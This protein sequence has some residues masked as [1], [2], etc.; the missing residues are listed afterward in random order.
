MSERFKLGA[1]GL[2]CLIGIQAVA[3]F[4][5]FFLHWRGFG[6]AAFSDFMQCALLMFATLA[7]LLNVQKTSQRARLFWSLM[8]LGLASWLIYRMLWTYIEVVQGHEV[9]DPF[10]ADAILFLHFVPM[11]AALVLQPDIR[12]DDTELRLGTL[13]FALLFLWW[14]YLYLYAVIPWQFVQLNESA[15]DHNWDTAYVAEKAAFLLGLALVWWRSSGRWRTTYAH[16][17][18]ASLLYSLSSYVANWAL[19]RNQYYSGSLYDLPLMASMA[20]MTMAGLLALRIP[21]EQVGPA[22]S[23]ARG[24]WTSRIGMVAVF[25]LPIFAYVS[26]FDSSIPERVRIFRLVLTLGAVL[27]MGCLV[28]LKQHFLDIE[29]IRLLRSSRKSF[30]DLQLLQAQLVQSE[31]LASLGQLVGG[32][33]HELN[34]PLT[35]ML[36]YSEL[37]GNTELSPDQRS[38]SEKIA[39]Q[40]KRV[41]TLVASLLSFAK[42]V[43]SAKTPQDLNVIAQTALKLCQPQLHAACVQTATE[44]AQTPPLARGDANQLLQV[45]THIIQNAANAM[46]DRGGGVLTVATQIGG[47][48]V[49]IQFSDTG[50]GMTEPDRVF[51]PFYTTRPVGQGTGLGLSMCYGVVQEH[52][53]KIS[54]R[55]RDAGGAIFLIE[56]PAAIVA[57][58]TTPDAK[59]DEP[60]AQAHVAGPSH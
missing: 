25:S 45:F 59:A 4:A 20:W 12:Q 31:K 55:N 50:P 24:V 28:F 43:P 33:A 11:M 49:M 26:L 36:G 10:T 19:D 16:W 57:L 22:K 39:Q 58:R 15:Y 29:L 38:L 48:S 60:R 8:G 14:V 51:D 42:Q 13:D 30:Q 7:C 44:L 47:K 35:A 5:A 6:L 32:A 37:L 23:L 2:A 21:V 54:C 27:L 17:F 56:L 18:G 53:G 41:R 3:S 52:G 40:A 1:V 9:P 34:N 46:A